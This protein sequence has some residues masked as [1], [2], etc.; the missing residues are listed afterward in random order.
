MPVHNHAAS[1]SGHTH[2]PGARASFLVSGGGG[3][4]ALAG[5]ASND[6]SVITASGNANITVANAGGGNSHAL[7]QPTIIVNYILRV[8]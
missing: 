5:G 6:T 4:A 1:D 8:I 3:L 2:G 7:L